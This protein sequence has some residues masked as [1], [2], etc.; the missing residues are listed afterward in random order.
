M[1]EKKIRVLIFIPF[2]TLGGAERQAFLLAKHLHKSEKYE[3]EVWAFNRKGALIDWLRNE[4][5][6]S[7]V[8]DMD[9]SFIHK[10][11]RKWREWIS[12]LKILRSGRADVII[13]FTWYP[14]VA[15]N[16][17]WRLT[18]AK[19]CVWNQRAVES[20]L[21]PIREE[22]IAVQNASLIVANSLIAKEVLQKKFK[23]PE[24]RF[25][26]I[27]NGLLISA[28]KFSDQEWRKRIAANEQT[29]VV[30]MTANFFG[31]KDH[32]TVIKA[33]KKVADHFA[34]SKKPKLVFAG[35]AAN[36]KL[37][38]EAQR[39]S[40]QLKIEDSVVFLGETDDVSGLLN[41]A[42][43]GLLSSKTEGNPNSIIEYMAKSLPVA[44]TDIPGIRE[45]VGEEN[46]KFLF[47]TGNDAACARILITLLESETLRKNAGTFN[48]AIATKNFSLQRMVMEYETLI[49]NLL[50]R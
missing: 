41:I 47:E 7:R 2:F 33:W 46:I 20:H 40:H 19:A 26:L 21:L 5:I 16:V 10:G 30:I 37:F 32:T 34:N 36:P 9:P 27:R 48:Y 38:E 25:K 39:L 49:Q 43:V 11:F 24:N 8:I 14:N 4:G 28:A 35:Y 29:P 13:P 31:E 1:P 6:S 17:L 15:C 23:L 18:S 22:K 50:K 12:F 45:V 3:V 42:T 44:G